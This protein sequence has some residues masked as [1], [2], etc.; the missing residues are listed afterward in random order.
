MKIS[1]KTF[2]NADV[3]YILLNFIPIL[4]SNILLALNQIKIIIIAI[5]L[6]N[7]FFLS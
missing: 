1:I 3:T 5:Q 6:I 7:Y 4:V 2:L